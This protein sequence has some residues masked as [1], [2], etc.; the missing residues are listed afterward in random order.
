MEIKI[1]ATIHPNVYSLFSFQ[2]V[3]NK[4]IGFNF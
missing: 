1:L 4:S 3:V 2:W